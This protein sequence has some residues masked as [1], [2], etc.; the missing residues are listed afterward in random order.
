[1]AQSYRDSVSWTRKT[2]GYFGFRAMTLY[3]CPFVRVYVRDKN[4]VLAITPKPYRIY[5]WNFADDLI[6]SRKCVANSEKNSGY[7]GFGTIPPLPKTH[8]LLYNAENSCPAHNS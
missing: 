7:F 3:P 6:I 1:M 5:S 4:C 2:T 8:V